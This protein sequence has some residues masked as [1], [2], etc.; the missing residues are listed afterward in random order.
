MISQRLVTVAVVRQWLQ[1]S[2]KVNDYPGGHGLENLKC[3]NTSGGFDGSQI[4]RS[5]Q[6]RK[7]EEVQDLT[8]NKSVPE[9]LTGSWEPFRTVF[10]GRAGGSD[11][12]WQLW[13]PDALYN[14]LQAQRVTS[15]QPAAGVWSML[16]VSSRCF[17]TVLCCFQFPKLSRQWMMIVSGGGWGAPSRLQLSFTLPD[18]NNPPHVGRKTSPQTLKK[19]KKH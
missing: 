6:K 3:Q 4:M 16:P 11:S 2:R 9:K 1:S 17:H 12:L 19:K 14:G 13:V 8:L 15:F 18:F 10:F 7:E 5:E